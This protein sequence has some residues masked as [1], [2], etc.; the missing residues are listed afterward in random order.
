M[1]ENS[2]EFEILCKKYYKLKREMLRILWE[3]SPQHDP[4]LAA[5]PKITEDKNYVLK[6]ELGRGR[7]GTVFKAFKYGKI[8]AAKVIDKNNCPSY[9][10]IQS[11]S[12]EISI[13]KTLSN[14]NNKGIIQLY[15]VI[16]H[17]EELILFTENGDCDLF[18]LQNRSPLKQN[19]KNKFFSEASSTLNFLSNMGVIHRDIKPENIVCFHTPY[20]HNDNIK[21]ENHYFKLIDFGLATRFANLPEIEK[22]EK[23]LTHMCGSPGFFAPEMISS[24]GY[25]NKVD[26]WSLGAVFLEIL[27]TPETFSKLWMP[28][29]HPSQINKYHVLTSNIKKTLDKVLHTLKQNKNIDNEHIIITENALKIDI[30]ERKLI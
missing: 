9:T 19:S 4:Q 6:E 20:I 11:L 10:K 2:K 1:S 14:N 24:L 28:N 5:L 16:S 21:E 22:N 18:E 26:I 25:N 23:K 7:C 15:D 13:L 12:N 8:M 29:Y 17:P 3:I 30:N 27:I